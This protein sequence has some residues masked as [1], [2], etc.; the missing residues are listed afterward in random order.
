[1][2]NFFQ[3]KRQLNTKAE[4]PKKIINFSYNIIFL[5][6]ILYYL[7][8]TYKHQAC[9]YQEISGGEKHIYLK[10]DNFLK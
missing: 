8:F 6:Q 5:A 10:K 1:M 7:C 2:F 3:I 9:K 4:V